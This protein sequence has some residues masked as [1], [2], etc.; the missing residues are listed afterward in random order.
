VCFVEVVS[1]KRHLGL[2][3]RGDKSRGGRASHGD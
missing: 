3:G 2:V 1:M